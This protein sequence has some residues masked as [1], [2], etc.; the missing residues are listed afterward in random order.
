MEKPVRHTLTTLVL[1]RIS[2]DTL[3]CFAFR[4][5]GLLPGMR[6]PARDGWGSNDF[7]ASISYTYRSFHLADPTGAG[8]ASTVACNTTTQGFEGTPRCCVLP[9]AQVPAPSPSFDPRSLE[10]GAQA[11][12]PININLWEYCEH[13]PQHLNA[14]LHRFLARLIVARCANRRTRSAPAAPRR[15]I[16]SRL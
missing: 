12:S 11:Q 5:G 10:T 16:R 13:S 2:S 15:A 6:A 1:L 3:W 9:A 7:A 14:P 8:A 4:H